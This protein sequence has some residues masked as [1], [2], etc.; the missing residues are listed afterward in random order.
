MADCIMELFLSDLFR[1]IAIAPGTSIYF[2]ESCISVAWREKGDAYIAQT[3]VFKQ[4]QTLHHSL[5]T[6]D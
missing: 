3:W 5:I 6:N 1:P 2:G 4:L